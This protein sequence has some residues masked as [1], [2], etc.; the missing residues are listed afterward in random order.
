M[1][2]QHCYVQRQRGAISAEF[3]MVAAFIVIALIFIVSQ[4]PK[5]VFKINEMR[6]VSQASE[7]SQEAQAWKKFRPNF[8]GVTIKV[9]CEDGSL[10]KSICGAAND[11]KA[12]NPF[13]G[14]W[15]LA[16]PESNL[17]TI[18]VTGKIPNE[19]DKKKITSVANAIAPSTRSN[20]MSGSN[21][22]SLT[23][24]ADSL[25]MIY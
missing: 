12:T 2:S 22:S 14:D 25:T 19:T 13:G 5:L 20:C 10:S 6:F 18:A 17:G 4:A 9:V 15:I 16:A 3:A 11:G 24:G 23:V 1:K 8:K 7:I 21:C